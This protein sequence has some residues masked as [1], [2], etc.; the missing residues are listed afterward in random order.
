[1]NRKRILIF[2]IALVGLSVAGFLGYQRLSTSAQSMLPATSIAQS[3]AA[4]ISAEGNIVP[5][6]ASDLAFRTGGHPREKVKVCAD[7]THRRLR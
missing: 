3:K 2:V 5:K 1:M 7:T 6:S 4:V